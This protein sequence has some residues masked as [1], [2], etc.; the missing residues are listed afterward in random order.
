M[1]TTIK[2]QLEAAAETNKFAAQ[3]IKELTPIFKKYLNTKILLA[4]NE[5]L[6]KKITDEVK[7]LKREERGRRGANYINIHF[8]LSTGK[9]STYLHVKTCLNGGSYEDRTAFTTYHETSFYL[10]ETK[11]GILTQVNEDFDSYKLDEK[12]TEKQIIKLIAKYKEAK[13]KANELLKQIPDEIIK[14]E[15]LR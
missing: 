7:E 9:Y 3:K 14:S 13:E 6:I 8:W 10:L 15:Y 4:S 5:E 11:D 2:I 12:P 1:K